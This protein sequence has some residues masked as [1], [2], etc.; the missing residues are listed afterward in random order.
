MFKNLLAVDVPSLIEF[1]LVLIAPVAVYLVWGMSGAGREI[2]EERLVWSCLFLA[3]D[4]T[5]GLI[6]DLIVEVAAI[7]TNLSLVFHQVWLVLVGL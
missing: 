7:G 1:S 5:D 3:I 4:L 2:E 6:G